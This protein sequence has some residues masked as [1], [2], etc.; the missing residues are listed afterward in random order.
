MADVGLRGIAGAAQPG[1][2]AFSRLARIQYAAL[3]RM[4][5]Q[6]FVNALRST[7]GAIE[8]GARAVSFLVYGLIGLGLGAG[9]GAATYAL[10]STQRWEFLP[11]EFWAVFLLWQATSVALASFQEQY[12][13]SGLLRFPV[14][15]GSFVLLHLIF[16]LIDIST[17]VGG[18]CSLGVLLGITIARPDLAGWAVVALAGFMLFNVFLARAILAWLDR[19]LARRRSREI[20]SALFVLA[21]LS[22]QLLNPAVRNRPDDDAE[23]RVP[24]AE[25]RHVQHG[26]HPLIAWVNAAQEWLPPG[27]SAQVLRRAEGHA[28]L[29]A[30]GL[31]AVL[32]GYA[33]G[34]GLLLALRLR[35]EYR[36]ENLSE[37]P[38]R[39]RG[40]ERENAYWISGG[41][42]AA[43]FEKELRTLMRS[44]PQLFGLC[45]PLAMVFIIGN[46]F[47]NAGSQRPFRL[48]LLAC[49]AYG[50]LGF[51][52]LIYNSLG[53]EGKAI[54]LLFL[55]PTPVRTVLLG[56]NLFHAALF[57]LV[58]SLSG[59]LGAARLGHSSVEVMA[60]TA[61]WV[62]FALPANLAAGDILSLTMPYRVNPGRLGRQ[63]GSQANALL[64]MLIQAVFLGVGAGVISLF[65]FLGSEW[66]AVIVLALLAVCAWLGW[67]AVLN[68]ADWIAARRRD[69]LIFR[70]A[71]VE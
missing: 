36:G 48:A 23:R 29:S 9:T 34:A 59:L 45:I 26:A 5:A 31:L 32:G 39:K 38:A 70:L 19:W 28:P 3:A 21:M 37:A 18:L 65:A 30:A 15:F 17:I 61:A 13:L 20:M 7:T 24:H 51:S 33:M 46:L 10:V 8:F 1:R 52:Q 16:G 62:A 56:K 47:R 63:S 50:L 42:I 43:V 67:L 25:A 4:R 12:D 11:V 71:K 2:G 53:A 27:V 35:T 69:E 22:L 64:S 66:L 6:L 54:Q 44:A 58:A 40:G 68:K 57:I 60:A 55:S 14:S 41:P 49:V